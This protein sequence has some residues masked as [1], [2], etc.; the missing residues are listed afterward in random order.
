MNNMLTMMGATMRRTHGKSFGILFAFAAMLLCGCNGEDGLDGEDGADGA[1]Y[2]AYSWLIIPNWG[3]WNDPNL[4]ST[5]T[6]GEPY[7]ISYAGTYDYIYEAWN[8]SQW[9]GSY[10]TY[11]NEG[12]PGEPGEPGDIFWSDGADGAD[13]VDGENVWFE[14]TFYSTGPS[15]YAWPSESNLGK[16]LSTSAYALEKRA[17]ELQNRIYRLNNSRSLHKSSSANFDKEGA[18]LGDEIIEMGRLGR[19]SWIFSYRRIK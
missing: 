15:F 1:S 8:G 11:I 6:T 18:D 5:V 3:S 10:T 13:G 12:L 19:Y 7:L 9:T 4:P 16:N 2:I 14:L 17:I